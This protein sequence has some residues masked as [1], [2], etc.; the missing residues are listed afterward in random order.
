MHFESVNPLMI[1]ITNYLIMSLWIIEIGKHLK[2]RFA[3]NFWQS[4]GWTT[5]SCQE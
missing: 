3:A 2:Q 5:I 4:I 1:Q